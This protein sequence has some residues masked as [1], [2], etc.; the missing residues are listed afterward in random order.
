MSLAKQVIKHATK[1]IK[2]LSVT[3]NKVL[4]P[5]FI[6]MYAQTTDMII[7]EVKGTIT[8]MVKNNRHDVAATMIAHSHSANSDYH[9]ANIRN[10]STPERELT[11]TYIEN[12][13]GLFQVGLMTVSSDEMDKFL[14]EN[15]DMALTD[16]IQSTPETPRIYVAAS[17]TSAVA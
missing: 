4:Q 7:A 2:Y 17:L 11:S 12:K 15:P 3:D 13:R 9:A 16:V 6:A 1:G 10:I 5:Q 8:H 14:A